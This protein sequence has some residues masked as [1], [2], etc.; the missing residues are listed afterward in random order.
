MKKEKSTY[1]IVS[2]QNPLL[3]WSGK[4]WVSEYPDA[5][6]YTDKD[7]VRVLRNELVRAEKAGRDAVVWIDYG[8]DSEHIVDVITP[9]QYRAMI[10][11]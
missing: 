10:N 2:R 6:Q 5:Q 9:K 11:R 3:F 7:G 8:L 1:V 4:R